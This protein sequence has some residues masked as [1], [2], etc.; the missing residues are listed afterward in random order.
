MLNYV[1][2]IL[3]SILLLALY[4]GYRRGFILGLLDLFA[5]AVSLFAAFYFYLYIATFI[6]D[7]LFKIE[8]RLLFPLSFFISLIIIRLIIGTAIL[9][10]YKMIS[11][12]IHQS[13]L[14]RAMGLLPGLVKGLFL[15]ALFSIIFLFVPFWPELPK[16]AR[17]SYFANNLSQEVETIDHKIAPDIS[18]QVNQSISKLTIEPESDKTIYLNFKVAHPVPN[19]QMENHM[20][21]LVNEERKKAGLKPL[22]KDI[23]MRIVARLHSKDMFQKGYFS[24]INL[25]NKS[26]FD[27]MRAHGII[28]RAAGENLALS[29]TVEI[30][31]LGLMN[32]PGH[33]ANILNPKFN[34]V[35]IG[36]MDGGI[37]GIMITQNFRN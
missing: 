2:L 11:N 13:T 12:K 16:K 15:T 6:D 18:E 10:L 22:E 28:Y 23:A 1:D 7:N 30:A 29:Q 14:N 34:R 5:I 4:Q 31:H 24:H 3:V 26:P 37:Y 17:E 33:R 8:E 9:G 35:G 36:I 32:S 25:D 27:R 20:L 19:E 21:V